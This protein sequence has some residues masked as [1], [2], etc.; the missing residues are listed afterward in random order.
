[1]RRVRRRRPATDGTAATTESHASDSEANRSRVVGPLQSG[2]MAYDVSVPP[3]PESPLRLGERLHYACP[4]CGS[5]D[6]NAK[7]KWSSV[8]AEDRLF[9][10]CFEDGC[11]IPPRFYMP[12]LSE[13][14]GLGEGATPDEIVTAM[15]ARIN[16]DGDLGVSL[17]DRAALTDKYRRR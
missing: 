5:R 6:A 16:M 12:A 10:R 1:M 11:P 14:L 9:I 7:R 15:F 4:F 13:A 2:A 8:Y 17:A 3:Q